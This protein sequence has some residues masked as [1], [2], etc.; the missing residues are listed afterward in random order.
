[1]QPRYFKK[2]DLVTRRGGKGGERHGRYPFSA[3]TL[4]RRVKEGKFPAPV[5]VAGIPCWPVD[6]LEQWE[7]EQEAQ[8]A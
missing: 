5:I 1:M 8:H 3:T 7:R 4:W 6:V 2:S